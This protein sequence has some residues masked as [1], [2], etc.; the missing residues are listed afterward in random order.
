MKIDANHVSP[1]LVSRET[2]MVSIVIT[3]YNAERFIGACIKAAL[4]QTYPNFEVLVVD[5]GSTDGT[6]KICRAITDPRFHYVTWGRLGRPKALNAGIG[7]TKGAYVAI[8]DA[9]DLSF[10]HRLQYSMVFLQEHPEMAYL[11]TGFAKTDT[12]YETIPKEVLVEV[13]LFEKD[14]PF[15]PSRIDLFRRNLFNNSTLL[16]PKSTWKNIG[17]YDEQ[18]SNSEDYDFYLRALQCG[19]AVLLPGRTVLWYTNPNG[20]FKQKSKREHFGALGSIKRR[21]HRLLHLPGW[22]R[23]YHPLW[24]VWCELVQRFPGLMDLARNIQKILHKPNVTGTA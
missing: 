14:S 6:A 18:L 7:E 5:D 23:L 4:A 10:P 3:A 15:V 9:D 21:A 13:P 24:V 16:Y 20:Y 12:F 22:L 8:N 19:P 2:P 11:G 1:S 17:G